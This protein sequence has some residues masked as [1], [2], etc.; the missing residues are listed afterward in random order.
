VR[1]VERLRREIDEHNRRYY[2]D[3]AP[4]V[5]DAEYDRLF[6]RLVEL[7]ERYP[8]L[9]SA[10]SPTQRVGAAPAEKFASV[11]HTVP[12]L[13]LDNAMSADELR[14]FDAR[15]RRL[16]R[17][18]DPVEYV[19]EPKLDGVA[20]EVVYLDGALSIA[21]TRGDGI[22][23]ED[24]TANVRTIRSV[25]PR[26]ARVRGRPAPARLEARGEVIFA[27]AA[28][29][30]LNAERAAAGAPPFANP[31]NAAAG[32][33]RQL[34]S[35]MTATRPLDIFMHSVGVV[36][37]AQFASHWE[38]LEALRA[39]GLKVNPLNQR[40]RGADE[41]IAY[42]AQIAAARDTLPYE[43]DGVV[44]KVNGAD[45]RRRLGEVSRSPRWAIAF[46]FK[47]QQGQTKVRNIIPSVGRTGVITPVAELEPV[48]V[49]GVTIANASLHNMD[50]VERKDVRIGDT[51]II[52]RAG[53]VIPYVVEV[54][55]GARTGNEIKFIMPAL[56]PVCG[57]AVIREEG[58]AAYRCIGMQCPAKRRE[59]IRHFAS[60]YALDIDG[61]GE[62]LVA[63][64]VDTGVVADV[65]DLYRLTVEQLAG[66]ER[67]GTKSAT[68]LY[69]AIQAKKT[70]PL[71]RL[72]YALGI[73]QVGERTAGL[74]AERFESL[75]A[76]AAA[77][78]EALMAIRDI[79]P[80]TAREIRAFFTLAQNAQ[81]L[82]R[83]RAVGVHEQRAARRAGGGPL[84]GKTMVIT[85]TLSVSRDDMIAR[86][87]AAGGKVTG[88]ISK[89]TDYLLA[90]DDPG[91]KLDKARK[92]GIEV[93]DES[94]LEALLRGRGE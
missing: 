28:F 63:Q 60:K 20:V 86:I 48:A 59:V 2:V 23:G 12:M 11:R 85:G 33:L 79:G 19:V 88:G 71:D 31:R 69:N 56:C 84:R 10:A 38:L 90:G 81:T 27:R 41:I 21:S 55:T 29:D 15:V 14:E 34:D 82:A 68:N 45:L 92:L 36:E 78:E 4:S 72:I 53:D 93:L 16:L 6:R 87:E 58:A 24:V 73:P 70:P 8:A 39:W 50:E 57:G 43:A 77:D 49:G 37:G 1:E 30:Q 7:E 35:R 25:V 22:T 3:D 42:H 46:K 32:S 91:S 26:L 65:S 74:L 75:A 94:G 18:D 54:V 80:E 40:C 64:L 62:K 61:L 89:K 76:L 67:M 66:L 83:L 47:A 52:E 13:S 51:V 5:S 9:R 17:S 44:A